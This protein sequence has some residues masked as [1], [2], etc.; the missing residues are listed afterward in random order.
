MIR[1]SGYRDVTVLGITTL[2]AEESNMW[3]AL[4]VH[5][6][7]YVVISGRVGIT[8]TA[9]CWVATREP[10]GGANQEVVD[11]LSDQQSYV[12]G[13]ATYTLTWRSLGREGD[14]WPRTVYVAVVGTTGRIE[15]E[16]GRGPPGGR[17]AP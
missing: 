4:R 9:P 7:D 17:N 13:G 12:P 3:H 2:I 1:A 14:P 15:V 16:C 11:T 10:T 6:G 5:V 8:G